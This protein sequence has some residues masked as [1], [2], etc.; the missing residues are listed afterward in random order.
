M[1]SIEIKLK[2]DNVDRFQVSVSITGW[3]IGRITDLHNLPEMIA[4]Q[5]RQLLLLMKAP[6]DYADQ[7]VAMILGAGP[8][9]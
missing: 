7:E 9:P 8:K 4:E 5:Y 2:A 1:D 6:A 3:P